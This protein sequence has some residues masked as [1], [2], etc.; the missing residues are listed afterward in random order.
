MGNAVSEIFCGTVD[1]H[2]V[3]NDLTYS[4]KNTDELSHYVNEAKD[5]VTYYV[6]VDDEEKVLYKVACVDSVCN[7]DYSTSELPFAEVTEVYNAYT[8]TTP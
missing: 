8:V 6:T 1:P 3:I 4:E 2:E 7:V 5:E